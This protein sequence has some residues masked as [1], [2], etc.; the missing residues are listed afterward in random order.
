MAQSAKRQGARMLAL[1][2][3]A[4]AAATITGA[5]AA[6]ASAPSVGLPVLGSYTNHVIF[7]GSELTHSIPGAS[8]SLT[9]P[10]DITLLDG[11]IYVGFQN[12]VGSDGSASSSGNLD[13]TIVE[14]SLDGHPLKQWDVAGKV[15]GLTADEYTDTLIATVNEDGNS[16][17][18]T[19]AAGSGSIT[20]YA[21]NEPLPHYG[22]TDAI[23][24]YDGR[25]LISA[26]APGATGG[27]TDPPAQPYPAVYQ[28]TLN[29]ATRTA[30]I[31]TLFGD[32]SSAAVANFG[33][34]GTVTLGLT[35]PD[36]S[37]I[38]PFWAR[39]FGGD[40][41]LTSQGD[42]Q[43]IYV[44]DPGGAHQSL[45]VLNL[46]NSVDDSAWPSLPWGSLYVTDNADD[47]VSRV[48]GPFEPGSMLVAVTPCDSNDALPTCGPNYLGEENQWTGALTAVPLAGPPL[49]AQGM[50]FV[51]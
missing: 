8:E 35:D 43:Q 9:K 18:Y 10:D 20:H 2:A 13:S 22:G 51:P 49:Q 28:V 23:S 12:G 26:S 32:E 42:Q 37:E 34:W 7:N 6:L 15:D 21:Y 19:V 25:L 46:S 45:S 36:S 11:R 16:S 48:S 3:V 5:T 1:A 14:L 30:T 33:S 27:P 47:T 29:P 17:L 41:M 24:V 40:F 38:V 4:A 31:A 50:L 44:S 39:R